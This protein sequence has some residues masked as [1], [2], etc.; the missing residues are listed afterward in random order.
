MWQSFVGIVSSRGVELFCAEHPHTIKFLWHR[1]AR[2]QGRV[3]CFWAVMP[4]NKASLVARAVELG[5][6]REA[7]NTIRTHARECGMLL[8]NDS[9]HHPLQDH[10]DCG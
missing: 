4:E 2:E 8:P 9:D 1:F 7:F 6:S 10:C 5:R 3:S